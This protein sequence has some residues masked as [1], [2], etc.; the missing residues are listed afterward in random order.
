MES[1]AALE[2]WDICTGKMLK[3]KKDVSK[4]DPPEPILKAVGIPWVFR[5]VLGSLSG[6]SAAVEISRE[7][8]VLQFCR[9][10]LSLESS[11]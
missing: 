2:G 11:L 6:A 5:K 4:S 9:S 1:R 3:Y 8:T 7:H 10:A